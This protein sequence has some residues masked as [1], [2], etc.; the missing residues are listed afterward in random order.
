MKK[1]VIIPII[2]IILFSYNFGQ[3]D[4][5]L[6]RNILDK[7]DKLY[8][9][10]SS[11]AL[12]EMTIVT[13]HWERTLKMKTWSEGMDKT[14]IRII[15][16]KKEEGVGTLRIENQ[17]WNYLPKTNKV[18]KIPPSMMMAS[19]MGSDFTNDDLVSE[20]TFVEDY[21]FNMTEVEN[22]DPDL[23]YV[24]AVPK[25]DRPIVWGH[26]ILAVKKDSFMPVWEKYFDEKG[27][28]MR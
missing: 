11:Y 14:F 1:T 9:S 2:F 22:P 21:E 12:M 28:L 8:R 7:V 13:P 27:R 25:P 10:E 6:A 18:M 15:E 16:P 24:K 26:I 17:M 19:W 23:Y 4:N 20:Y 3:K 5:D